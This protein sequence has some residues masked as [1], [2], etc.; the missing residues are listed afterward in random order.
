MNYYLDVLKNYAGFTGRA[1]R[2]E[3]W[4]FSLFHYLI[5]AI[6][7][8]PFFVISENGQNEVLL[9]VFGGLFLIYALVT[10]IPSI[11][12]TVRRLHDTDKSG[13]F[14][15]VQFIPYVGGI[16]MLVFTV[17]NGTKGLNKYGPDPKGEQIGLEDFGLEE[18]LDI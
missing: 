2:K 5:F 3:Y 13:W 18:S 17:S 12:V 4:M 6:L 11:A 1:R 15:L 9:I 8:I 14:I 16:I 7:L 10:F